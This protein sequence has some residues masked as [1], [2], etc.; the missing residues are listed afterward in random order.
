MYYWGLPVSTVIT[1]D[2]HNIVTSVASLAEPLTIF[3]QV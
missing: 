1:V 2:V 3:G